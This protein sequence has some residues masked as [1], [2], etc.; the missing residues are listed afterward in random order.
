MK[1]VLR[2][3][4]VLLLATVP[5][6]G[7]TATTPK[8]ISKA[9][10]SAMKTEKPP[11]ATQQDIQAIRQLLEQQQQQ[12]QQL[13]QQ[14]QQRD[15]ALQQT[16]QQLQHAQTVAQE[17]QSRLAAM[18]GG[19]EEQQADVSKLKADV[20]DVQTTLKDSAVQTQDDQEKVSELG[21]VLGRFRWSGDARV[22]YENFFQE[23]SADRHRPRI[24][25]RVG[26]ESKLNEDF[27]GGIFIATGDLTDPVSTNQTLT[28]FFERKQIGLDRGWISY[29]PRY[30][31]WLSLTGGKFAYSWT[32]TPLTFDNDLNP[33]GFSEKLSF[34]VPNNVVKNIS[35]TGMQLMFNESGSGRDSWAT[36]GQIGSKLQFGKLL[37]ITPSVSLLKWQN[38][39]VIAVQRAANG[40]TGNA[41]T[42]AVTTNGAGAVTGFASG[43]FYSDYVLDAQIRTPSEKLPLRL[44]FNFE[45]NLDAIDNQ[46]SAGWAEISLGQVKNPKDFQFG[47]SFARIERDALIAV[48][49]ESDLRQP[50]NVKQH[51]VFGQY[52]ITPNTTAAYTLW[53]GKRL[54]DTEDWLKR[55]QF[56]LMYKF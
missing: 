12:I 54:N 46:D 42:N 55:M 14:M 37:T 36:G 3:S 26:V 25:L 34:N 30:A 16:Q 31:K 45:R 56:D 15:Q 32:R 21:A 48:F 33:E 2:W 6:F 13:Q 35:F 4:A 22:R 49:N 5:V 17:A 29:N 19:S 28:G 1:A 9:R 52:Q 10:R 24:R 39:N 43:F 47:Y 41:Q 53:V 40:I 23:G 20:A 8:P 11:A 18:Q 27:S 44:L 38:E 51:R 50:T 7:Q